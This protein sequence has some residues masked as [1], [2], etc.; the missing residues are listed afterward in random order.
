MGERGR[1]VN[2]KAQYD[3]YCETVTL[4]TMLNSKLLTLKLNL[5]K[6]GL[7][8]LNWVFLLQSKEKKSNSSFMFSCEK[9]EDLILF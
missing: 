5:Q 6:K 2:C 1:G 9:S 3:C 7:A 4:I 8:I